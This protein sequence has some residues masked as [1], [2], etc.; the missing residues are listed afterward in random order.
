MTHPNRITTTFH[1]WGLSKREQSTASA[2]VPIAKKIAPM[3]IIEV[4]VALLPTVVKSST[5][6]A[7]LL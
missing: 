3:F 2:L 4:R 1:L 6:L 7:D 5:R